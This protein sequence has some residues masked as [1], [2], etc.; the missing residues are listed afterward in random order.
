MRCNFLKPQNPTVVS[1]VVSPDTRSVSYLISGSKFPKKPVLSTTV[2]TVFT[3]F[4]SIST[5]SL[6]SN[7]DY[8]SNW[9]A[10]LKEKNA[11]NTEEIVEKMLQNAA[12]M[13]LDIGNA[14]ILGQNANILG[15][16][17]AKIDENAAKPDVI[18]EKM[19]Q[20]AEEFGQKSE[21]T[22]KSAENTV[23][24]TQNS[25]E[26]SEKSTEISEKT[27]KS[28]DSS[29][30]IGDYINPVM[31]KGAAIFLTSLLGKFKASFGSVL[32]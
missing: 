23:K 20:S 25:G 18:T 15:L 24:V 2:S 12:K 31:A 26:I 17:A 10:K 22:E 3:T 11:K 21:N 30:E 14:D 6:R 4:S 27:E 32:G 13:G 9:D 8:L 29:V 5:T 1:K 7:Q 28:E 19:Y 16:N